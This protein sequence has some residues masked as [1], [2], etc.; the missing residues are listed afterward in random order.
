MGLG[1]AGTL[2]HRIVLEVC[3][4]SLDA[5]LAARDGGASRLEVCSALA[6]GGLTPNHEL[7]RQAVERSGLPVH[8]MI[9][10]RAG[11]FIYSDAELIAMQKSI[12]A[13]KDLGADGVVF[14]VLHLD[15][16]VDTVRTRILVDRARPM[17][18]T[19]HRAFD[20]TVDLNQAMEDVIATGCDRILTSGGA[21]D[22]VAG[23]A[24]LARLV[25]RAG[26]RIAI[27]VGGGLRLKN[28]PELARLTGAK[29]FHGS[30]KESMGEPV[31]DA[32]VVRRMLALLEGAELLS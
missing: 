31:V 15:Q 23:R 26:T 19:F 28:A 18:T 5:C 16:S 20:E 7:V 30:M 32:A 14:G 2:G 1:G 6:V 10:P 9:R 13:M 12:D 29:H 3:V 4:E 8:A 25:E 24:V 22:V 11:N 27:A 17:Q 21:S